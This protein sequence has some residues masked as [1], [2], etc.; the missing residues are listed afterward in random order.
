METLILNGVS[1]SSDSLSLSGCEKLKVLYA[2]RCELSS[3]TGVPAS[4]EEVY[5]SNNLLKSY[6]S[7]NRGKLRRIDLSNNMITSYV[8]AST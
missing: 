3:I 7:L 5:A 1:L 2:E 8:D 4:I 6:S